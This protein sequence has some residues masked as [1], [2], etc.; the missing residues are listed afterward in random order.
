M[1]AALAIKRGEA[2]PKGEAGRLAEQMSEKQ[3][4]DFAEKEKK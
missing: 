1:G 3:L 4:R 2:E